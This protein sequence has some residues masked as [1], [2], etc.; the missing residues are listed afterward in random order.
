MNLKSLFSSRN[1]TLTVICLLF[2]FLFGLYLIA[3]LFFF[4]PA[5]EN[6]TPV[7][8]FIGLGLFAVSTAGI[9]VFNN[10]GEE[11]IKENLY[12]GIGLSVLVLINMACV[13][14]FK[15]HVEFS[16]TGID[17]ELYSGSYDVTAFDRAKY[18]FNFSIIALFLYLIFV[19]FPSLT[20]DD[21]MILLFVFLIIAVVATISIISYITEYKKYYYFIYHFKTHGSYNFVMNPLGLH[22]N[23]YGFLLTLQIFCLLYLFNKYKKWYFLVIILHAYLN[24][25]FT[26]CKAGLLISFAVVFVY[27]AYLYITTFNQNKKRSYIILG[28]CGGL[29]LTFGILF[30]LSFALPN[31]FLGK[32]KDNIFLMFKTGEKMNTISSRTLIWRNSFAIL[33][34]SV[35]NFFNN[36][37]FGCG[38]GTFGGL[39]KQYNLADP[40]V[41]WF[42]KTAQAHN[43]WIQ[44][45]GEGGVIRALSALTLMVY[46]VISNVKNW[47]INRDLS[48]YSFV[49]MTAALIY[50]MFE[51]DPFIFA[52]SGEATAL[53][54]LIIVPIIRQQ[55]ISQ[56]N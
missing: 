54:F 45:L 13:L 19:Y 2:S 28:I 14:A 10:R 8:Y 36:Y 35:S 56:N 24:M 26:L 7:I 22:K 33:S 12:L 16:L 39:L 32:A 49:I 17:G 1:K 21:T 55:K 15:N 30:I 6:N 51:N 43:T 46:L 44:Y 11:P 41:A 18:I 9:F 29:V 37:I 25:I 50:G 42:N 40:N 27:L 20:K 53:S 48:F 5:H 47:K 3:D 34:S 52:P 4:S 38:N 31:S 23:V